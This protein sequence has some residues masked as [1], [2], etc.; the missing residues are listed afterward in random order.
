M[1]AHALLFAAAPFA[2]YAAVYGLGRW[3]MSRGLFL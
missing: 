3:L 2:A 1:I